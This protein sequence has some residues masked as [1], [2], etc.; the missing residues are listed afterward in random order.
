MSGERSNWFSFSEPQGE[1]LVCASCRESF[2][3]YNPSLEMHPLFC[4]IC[5]IECTFLDWRGRVVQ[6][7]PQNAPEV[8]ARFLQCLQANFDE[9]DYVE[10]L[11]CFEEMENAIK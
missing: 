4:P 8:F 1:I 11:A 9:L 6:L 3:W 10:L 7:I 5:K 2:E